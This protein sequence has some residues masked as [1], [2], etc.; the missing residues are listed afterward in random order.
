M[1]Q[2][3]PKIW[4]GIILSAL[5]SLFLIADAVMKLMNVVPVQEAMARLGYPASTTAGIGTALLVSTILY[6]IP[7]TAV[8]GAILLT[9]HLGGAT[10]T[11]VRVGEPFYFPIVFGV[12]VWAGLFLRE[13]RL[14]A[15]IPVVQIEKRS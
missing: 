5:C 11:H 7:R 4:A 3:P 6:L 1:M 2:T 10:A 9:G 13:S 15:L 12:L 14:R 8:I